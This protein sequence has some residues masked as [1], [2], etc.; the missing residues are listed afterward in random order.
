MMKYILVGI[1][2]VVLGLVYLFFVPRSVPHK[3]GEVNMGEKA[4]FAGGCFWCMEPAFEAL[5]GIYDVRAGYMGGTGKNPTYGDYARKGYIEVVQVTYDPQKVSYEDL[6]KAFWHSIDPTD[7]GGQF[8]DRGPQYRSVIFYHTDEQRKQALHSKETLDQSGRFDKP[9]V[10]EVLP[11]STF[12]PA[13]EYHQDYAKKNP[14]RYK[15]YRYLSGRDT[16]LKKAW[17]TS[18]D[19]KKPSD[20]ELKERLTPLAYRVTQQGATEPAY[21]NEYWDNK[22]PGIYVDVV[23]GEPLFSSLDKYDSKTGWPSFTKPLEPAN[24]QQ[25]EDRKLL[26]FVRTEVLSTHA[27]SHLGHVFNDGP[28]PT[29]LRY[30]L[31]SAALRFIPVE[32]LEQAGYGKYLP[33]FKDT[34][35]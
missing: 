18:N 20:K 23:S 21:D 31:N 29:G 4:T 34:G 12:Y 30:C 10:T 1:C 35:A 27:G 25:K 5:D 22:R 19:Y 28:P 33:L 9:V 8:A 16:F 3:K 14:W 11:A 2:L 32:E 17:S 7:Q 15:T 6:L 26:F 13:E 24:I